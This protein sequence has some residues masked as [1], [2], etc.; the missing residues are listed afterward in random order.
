M[1]VLAFLP[2]SLFLLA[3]LYLDS[4]KLVRPRVLI[5][6][7]VIGCLAA[8]ASLLLNYWLLRLGVSRDTLTRYAAPAVEEILKAIPI[9]V[10]LRDR[11][12]GFLIDAA[13]CGF[14]VG[15][16]FALAEN[17]YFVSS[18]GAAPPALWIV[19]GFGT[20]IMHGGTTAIMAMMAKAF[21]ARLAAVGIVIAFALHSLFNHFVLSPAMSTLVIILVLPPL[22]VLVFAQSER[23]VRQWLGTGFDLDA[24]LLKAM[25]SGEFADS[26][27]G[28][29]LQSLREHFD[30]AVLA[31]ML[32]YLRLQS[33]LSLRVKG[34]L[35]LRETGFP[36]KKDAEVKEKLTELRYLR[37]SMGKIGELA[38]APLLRD[39]WQL[40]MLE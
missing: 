5:E 13:I 15:T 32:C 14:A 18:L 38:L 39:V 7:I 10:M 6:L 40:H 21:G 29:Y 22:M 36:V 1:T 28:R 23:H 4:F 12:I 8:A 33:E 3:L 25:N 19:R 31:D 26:G 37:G 16:G 24:D 30:G 9:I 17:L 11:Q 20:A 2:V 27:A 35:M 34:I